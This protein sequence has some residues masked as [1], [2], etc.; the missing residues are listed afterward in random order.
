MNDFSHLCADIGRNMK[1]VLLCLLIITCIGFLC[2][3][4]SND[5]VLESMDASVF[6]VMS[7]PDREFFERFT[8]SSAE[9]MLIAVDKNGVPAAIADKSLMCAAVKA[10]SS[11]RVT[12]KT[13]ISIADGTSSGPCFV[14]ADGEKH[15]IRFE[16]GM[17]YANG[18]YYMIEN[19][20]D[21]SSFIKSLSESHAAPTLFAFYCDPGI[22]AFAESFYDT[23]PGS[24]TFFLNGEAS[25]EDTQTDSSV[26]SAVFDALKDIVVIGESD[27]PIFIDNDTT[28][29]FS[30]D[31]GRE[32]SFCF[33]GK[34]LEIRADQGNQYY[35]LYGDNELWRLINEMY[36]R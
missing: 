33:N 9:Y 29:V 30:Y 3:C 4:R 19:D 34:N 10:I 11:I 7:E 12:A 27:E 6:E 25:F 16:N 5:E 15:S 1:K 23:L 20:G 18:S 31:D 2:A 14:T 24:V 8:E 26:I 36:T 21:Y 13:N 28:I 32:Y 17:L 22:T 35:K